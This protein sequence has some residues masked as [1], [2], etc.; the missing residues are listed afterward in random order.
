MIIMNMQNK[1]YTT[2]FSHHLM[3]DSQSVPE[4]RL[5]NPELANFVNSAKLLKKTK[6]LETFELPDNRGFKPMEKRR[7]E[8]FLPSSQLP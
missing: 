6:L 1:P 7:A 4:Q 8:G 5:Q 2:Q 3:T